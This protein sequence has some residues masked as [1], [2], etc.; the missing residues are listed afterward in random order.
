MSSASATIRLLSGVA[1]T[2]LFSGGL[3]EAQTPVSAPAA[4]AATSA[5]PAFLPGDGPPPAVSGMIG[6]SKPGPEA[7]I[8]T[9]PAVPLALAEEAARG[10]LKFCSAGGHRIAVAV[11]NSAGEL[12]V[13][14]VA[15]GASAERVFVAARKGVAA[16]AFKSPTSEVQKRLRASDSSAYA[17]LKPNMAVWPG[18][19]PILAGERVLGAIGTSGATSEQDE[20]CAAAGLARIKARL[21]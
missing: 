1:V 5:D 15:D 8:D 18:A 9:P 7:P 11:V 16:I 6:P 13:G 14:L 12:Q 10:A 17:I 4:P 19:V 21:K 3:A 20:E 2:A